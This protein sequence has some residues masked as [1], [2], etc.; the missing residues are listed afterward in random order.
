MRFSKSVATLLA[1]SALGLAATSASATSLR[2][3]ITN[4]A[5]AGGVYLTPV[6][7]AFHDGTFDTFST[8]SGASAGL[9]AIA[10]DGNVAPL[11]AEF[12][13][14]QANGV[15]GVT[16]MAPVAPGQTVSQ[17]FEV[18]GDGSNSYFSYASMVLPSSDYFVGNGNPLAHD[19]SAIFDGLVN[20]IVFNIGVPGTVYDAGTEVNDFATSA[21]NGLFANIP[22]GQ[23][24]PNQGADENG[25]VSAVDNPFGNFLN[26]DGLDLALLNFGNASLY[27]NGIATVTITVV[28]VPAALPLFAAGLGALG[29]FRRRRA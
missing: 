7:S 20:E 1:M 21:G 6:W 4:N 26:A 8:G 27:A 19:I 25:L 29:F 10:E 22:G 24:G 18:S 5:P 12:G 14:A 17:T 23:M 15:Q 11:S 13:A 28:P 3:T 2:V 9:E 16:G